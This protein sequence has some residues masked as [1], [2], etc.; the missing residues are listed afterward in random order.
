M[1]KKRIIKD[2]N[3]MPSELLVQLKDR[4]PL[5]FNDHLLRFTNAKGEQV[6]ALPFE[7]DETYYLV[8]VNKGLGYHILDEDDQIEDYDELAGAE[9]LELDDSEE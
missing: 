8:K 5:G 1:V 7:T 4:Y 2:Y 6:S 9:E 3:Q